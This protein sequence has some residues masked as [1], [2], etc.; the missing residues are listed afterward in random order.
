METIPKKDCRNIGFFRKTHGVH[1]EIVLEY[2]PEFELS[3]SEAERFFVELDGLLVP[4]FL[5]E[6]GFRFKTSKTAIL[7]FDGVDS[8]NYARRLVG[9]SV[10]LFNDEIIVDEEEEVKPTRFIDYLLSDEKLGEIGMV[11]NVDDYSGNIVFSVQYK[12]NEILIPYNEDFLVS[13]NDQQ[14]I[15]TMK[16]PEGLLDD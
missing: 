4:F 9:C 5:N 14:K 10:F 13:I 11:K 6:D 3:I 8:E 2:E 16:L 1:G 7:N 12:G 15:L